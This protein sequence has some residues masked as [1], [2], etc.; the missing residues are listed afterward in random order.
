VHV[1]G[2][3]FSLN[4][5]LSFAQVI[6]QLGNSCRCC[7]ACGHHVPLLHAGTQIVLNFVAA[8]FLLSGGLD[9]FKGVIL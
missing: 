6:D 4:V 9:L 7:C 5:F 2:F 8:V 1:C 3:F